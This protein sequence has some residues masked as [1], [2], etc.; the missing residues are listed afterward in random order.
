MM[1]FKRIRPG[2]YE[3]LARYGYVL[4]ATKNLDNNLWTAALLKERDTHPKSYPLELISAVYAIASLKLAREFCK[5]FAAETFVERENL[6]TRE[7]VQISIDTP[8]CC[9]VS[10]ET[11]WS[12]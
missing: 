3:A 2:V 6:M 4:R 9:D 12:I 5:Q 8:S 1:K 10:T 7:K 11:Y